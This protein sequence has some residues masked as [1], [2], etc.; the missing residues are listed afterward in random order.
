MIKF[1]VRHNESH[2]AVPR[3]QIT[4]FTVTIQRTKQPL[5]LHQS[6]VLLYNWRWFTAQTGFDL[7]STKFSLKYFHRPFVYGVRA[8]N[9]NSSNVFRPLTAYPSWREAVEGISW[10]IHDLSLPR[11]KSGPAGSFHVLAHF[12]G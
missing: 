7:E 5:E 1:V 9:I 3:G 10:A 6:V 8:E 12:V 11:N 2:N 4:K